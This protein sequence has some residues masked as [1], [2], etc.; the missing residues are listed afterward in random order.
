MG[1][2]FTLGAA[3][4]LLVG[5]AVGTAEAPETNP[6]AFVLD[7]RP[8]EE[9]FVVSV[10]VN[11]RG[12]F[13]F[14]IDTGAT[15]SAIFADSRERLGV[16]PH[17]NVEF[18]NV[19]G[20][21]STEQLPLFTIPSIR[22]G[23][24]EH[25]DVKFVQLPRPRVADDIDGIIGVNVLREYA[26]GFDYRSR[27]LTFIPRERFDPAPYRGWD[28]AA[29]DPDPF[30]GGDFGLHFA[31][32]EID[33]QTIPVLIDTGT[34]PSIVNWEAAE[35]SDFLEQLRRHLRRKYQIA[36]AI[37]S[38]PPR[39]RARMPTIRI[40]RH[41]WD[42][43]VVLVLDLEPLDVLGGDGRPLIIAGADMLSKRSF[44][45]DF[46]N[47]EMF[48]SPQTDRAED[49]FDDAEPRGAAQ[50]ALSPR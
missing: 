25:R 44:M 13:A 43:P 48:I 23:P 17:E 31:T 24:R 1:R 16:A 30:G 8:S 32:G 11:G 2:L 29:L 19:R 36:G 42:S 33:G 9:I 22:L 4:L 39:V 5:C 12:P 38:F 40:G 20:V 14:L 50:T 41:Y 37:D 10:V 6:H 46:E 3:M 26:F 35:V 34:T 27:R 47:N 15:V 49:D 21:V 7:A 45:I 18:A 28:L